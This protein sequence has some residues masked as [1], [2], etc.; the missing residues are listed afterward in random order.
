MSWRVA[1][2]SDGI[3]VCLTFSSIKNNDGNNLS[4]AFSYNNKGGDGSA[5]GFNKDE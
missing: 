4:F 1:V 3:L 2:A 5:D